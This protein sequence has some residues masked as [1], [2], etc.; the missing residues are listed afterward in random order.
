MPA[1]RRVEA[2]NGVS[3][4]RLTRWEL[5]ACGGL[6][7][8]VAGAVYGSHVAQTGSAARAPARATS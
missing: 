2:K 5:L 6:L 1:P 7:A 4:A 3:Q 8:L